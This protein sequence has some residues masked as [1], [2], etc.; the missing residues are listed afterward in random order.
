MRR[1]KYDLEGIIGKRYE[2]FQYVEIVENRNECKRRIH[3]DDH[4][5]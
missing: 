2:E 1:T 4:Q 3:V 5:N